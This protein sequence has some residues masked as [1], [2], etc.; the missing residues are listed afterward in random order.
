M[1]SIVALQAPGSE[2]AVPPTAACGW[3]DRR[4]AW[5]DSAAAADLSAMEPVAAADNAGGVI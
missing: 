1:A 2:A 3:I 4:A 5:G